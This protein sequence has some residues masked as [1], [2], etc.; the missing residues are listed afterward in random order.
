MSNYRNQVRFNEE[1]KIIG[2]SCSTTLPGSTNWKY[3]LSQQIYTASEIGKTGFI[4]SIAFMNLTKDSSRKFDVYLVPTDKTAFNDNSDWLAVSE[5]YKVFSGTVSFT[6]GEWAPIVFDTPYWYDGTKNLA[7]IVNDKTGVYPGTSDFAAYPSSSNASI[8]I[9]NDDNAYDPATPP[10]GSGK[11]YEMKNQIQFDIDDDYYIGD[12]SMNISV[13]L[14]T[15]TWYRRSL[16][17][18]LYTKE[19]L[20]EARDLTS[21]SFYNQGTEQTRNLNLYLVPTYATDFSDGNWIA[22]NDDNLVYSGNVTFYEEAWTTIPFDTPFSY[23]GK[24]NLVL[25]VADNTGTYTTAAQFRASS[26]ATIQSI[27]QYT[28]NTDAYPT[29]DKLTSTTGD[30]SS[31]KNHIKLNA[32]DED[33]T[34]PT[35]LAVQAQPYQ[36]TLTW[37]G[38]GSQWN[39]QYYSNSAWTTVKGLTDNEYTITGLSPNTYYRARVQIVR[40]DGTVSKWTAKEFYTATTRAV[41]VAA[42]PTP[43]SADIIWTG[44][45]DLYHVK[46]TSYYN[47]HEY[48]YENFDNG[49]LSGNGWTVKTNGEKPSTLSEGWVLDN[50]RSLGADDYNF[51]GTYSATTYSWTSDPYQS[52]NADNW[53]ISP[54]VDVKGTLSF[55][56]FGIGGGDKYEVLLSGSGTDEGDFIYTLRANE[57]VLNGWREVRIDLSQYSDIGIDKG[58][59]AI[60][61]TGYNGYRLRI[62]DFCIFEG[63]MG[64]VNADGT[65]ATINGLE[66][67]TT[68]K[69]RVINHKV[70][71]SSNTTDWLSFTTLEKNPAP[72]DLAA[73]PDLTSAE[74]TWTGFSDSYNLM[75]RKAEKREASDDAFFFEGFENGIPSEWTTIDADGDGNNWLALSSIPT[76]YSYY[77]D[78]DLSAWAYDGVDAALSASYANGAGEFHTDQYLITPQLDLKGV[79]KFMEKATDNSYP[80]NF[81]VLLSTTGNEIADFT[82][83]LRP[84][85][86]SSQDW[87]EVVIDLDA[88]EGQQGYIA[89]HHQ[90]Y[91]QYF[92][93]IDNFGLYETVVV[94]PA[95]EWQ[96]VEGAT[97]PYVLEGLDKKTEYDCQIVGIKEG[98][99]DA[100]S[101]IASFTTLILPDVVLDANEDNSSIISTYNGERVNVIIE[102]QTIKKDG[103]WWSICLPFDLE[104]E[105]SILEGIQLRQ[106]SGTIKE[107]DTY[108]I[109]D[110]LTEC[111]KIEAGKPYMYKFEPGEDIVNPVFED[112]VMNDIYQ[113]IYIDGKAVFSNTYS[114]GHSD[115]DYNY[116]MDGN[117]RLGRLNLQKNKAIKAFDCY[118]YVDPDYNATLDGIGLNFDD[119]LLD[120]LTGVDKASTTTCSTS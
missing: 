19:E 42:T 83:V 79:L 109:I 114:W 85:Q 35:D 113:Y 72:F 37:G 53:L 98:E 47:Y 110:C 21:I 2:L 71:E 61:F 104:L 54:L 40:A 48:F 28:D 17:Q 56:Q 88:Y 86:K 69:Y 18:Q 105:G 62:D 9:Y 63:E 78:Y 97:S 30:L 23:G 4:N 20:G 8:A 58:Y 106:P 93:A 89:I 115:D 103:K 46:Y 100:V 116:V 52:Y 33:L 96:I 108:L 15:Y 5:S 117:I 25:V 90:D 51:S 59:I 22:F 49:S 13:Y 65:T 91:N 27:R 41:D 107:V 102:N 111:D 32:V 50:A 26:G 101:D 76:T 31:F 44:Y 80:D 38:E 67:N 82:T 43:N 60:H 39:L 119:N 10:N 64:Y 99:E 118:F 36:V 120:I 12:G 73:T 45:S 94:E 77:A 92:L 16:T 95:G 24:T 1:D 112:V 70:G 84:M 68:Y 75:Y 34:R 11:C 87:N 55:W 14:P 29:A 7:V 66:P 81:E 57:N 74:I 3:N 6:K